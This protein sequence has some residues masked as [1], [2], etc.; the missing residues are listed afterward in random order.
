MRKL[1]VLTLMALLLAGSVEAQ[2][3]VEKI[4]RSERPTITA[5]SEHRMPDRWRRRKRKSKIVYVRHRTTS[6]P[7]AVISREVG[8]SLEYARRHCDSK[9][10]TVTYENRLHG[11]VLS[12]WRSVYW[13]GE[14]NGI[15]NEQVNRGAWRNGQVWNLWHYVKL[16][17]RVHTSRINPHGV[18]YHYDRILGLF[19]SCLPW[20]CYSR[21]EPYVSQTI[22]ANG[23]YDE[24]WGPKEG[25]I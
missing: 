20:L 12:F 6:P 15:T 5:R 8:V 25:Q 21:W 11:D 13:C 7:P 4:P 3:S 18:R 23:T 22:R 1:V 10:N 19:E 24:S 17:G 9:K 14:D 16:I 2:A